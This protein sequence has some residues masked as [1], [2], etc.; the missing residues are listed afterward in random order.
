LVFIAERISSLTMRMVLLFP[1]LLVLV[2]AGCSVRHTERAIATGPWRMELDLSGPRLPFLFDLEREPGTGDLR[3]LVHNSSETIVVDDV[4]QRGDSLFIRMPLYDSEFMGVLEADNKLAGTWINHLRGPDYRIP[5]TAMAGAQKR[6][7]AAGGDQ[8][9]AGGTWEVHFS[10]GT[11]KA[12]NAIGLFEQREDGTATGTFLTETGDHRFLEG[13]VQGDTLLLSSFDGSH[14]FLFKAAVRG[15]S[16][17]GRFWSG[18][19]WQEPW[20]AVRNEHFTLRHPDSLTVLKEGH[21]MVDFQFPDLDGKLVSPKDA[22]FRD[23]TLM[24]QVM[25]SWCPNCVDETRMLNEL[26]AKHRQHG[27]EIIAVA[28]EKYEDPARAK[29]ALTRFRDALQV[30]YPIVYAGLAS[31]DV[32]ASKLPFL[33]QVMSYPTCIIVDN[34]GVVRRIHTGFYG[35]GTGTH[36]TR[37]RSELEG[38]LERLL[39]EGSSASAMRQ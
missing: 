5:F 19:H 12:Y 34:K 27:L 29:A 2:F 20:T 38:F 28:F 4:V 17:T 15:D 1:L 10:E 21:T 11:A 36:H 13:A 32:A 31:K 24:V 25:G 39:L 23:K 18:T 26:Y 7:A 8:A 37:F 22:R 30:P 6:F 14:A 3:M 35:P 33:D 16:M 9:A